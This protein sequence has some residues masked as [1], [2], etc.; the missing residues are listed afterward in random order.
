MSTSE[1]T[2]YL[3]GAD[4]RQQGLTI[5][6]VFVK[7]AWRRQAGNTAQLAAARMRLGTDTFAYWV[8]RGYD[9]V[10]RWHA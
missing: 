8:R 6:D 9:E 4:C 1:I 7:A 10:T 2:A 3:Y 5:T